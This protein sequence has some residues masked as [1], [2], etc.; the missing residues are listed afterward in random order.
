MFLIGRKKEL[1]NALGITY[2]T[3][4]LEGCDPFS[5]IDAESAEAGLNRAVAKNLVEPEQVAVIMD[6]IRVAGVAPT[7]KAV[8]ELVAQAEVPEGFV[9]SFKFTPHKDCGVPL[10]HGCIVKTDEEGESEPIMTLV[11]GLHFLTSW[12]RDEHSQLHVLDGVYLMK[13]MIVVKL[14]VNEADSN[15]Q[16]LALPQEVR[17]EL[18]KSLPIRGLDMFSIPGFGDVMMIEIRLPTRRGQQAQAK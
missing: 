7:L 17:D 3:I 13:E 15:A 18:E 4:N 1:L 12:M 5:V 11:D 8:F 16:Y 10:P 2:G 6:Q 14:P 9:P